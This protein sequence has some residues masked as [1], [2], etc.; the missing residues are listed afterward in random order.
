MYKILIVDNDYAVRLL[1][2]S[3]LEDEGYSVM[4]SSGCLNI[5]DQIEHLRPDLVL[6]EIRLGEIDGLD[7]LQEIRD[8]YY[9][10]PV[11][12][13]SAYSSFRYDM[14]AIAADY[15]VTK[16]IDLSEL[17]FKV[18]MAFDSITEGLEGDKPRLAEHSSFSPYESKAGLSGLDNIRKHRSSQRRKGVGL[19]HAISEF[20]RTATATTFI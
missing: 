12:L 11:I 15:Y 13:C 1:Y 19:C 6:L 8:R 4:T 7:I 14:R 2:Q 9:D 3:E 16:S 10:M 20:Q 17:K 5:L 18:K